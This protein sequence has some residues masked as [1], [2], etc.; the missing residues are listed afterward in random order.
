MED[1]HSQLK[2]VK[3]FKEISSCLRPMRV[4]NEKILT[5]RTTS[6]QV[7]EP[8]LSSKEEEIND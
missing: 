8:P 6:S 1:I 4:I 2:R 3:N 7:W 5:T